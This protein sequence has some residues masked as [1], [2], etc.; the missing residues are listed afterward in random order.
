MDTVV[1]GGMCTSSTHLLKISKNILTWSLE[2]L[3]HMQ[4]G[5][6][7]IKHRTWRDLS[8]RSLFT[9]LFSEV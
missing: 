1:A 9:Y 8:F 2:K 5:S 6:P 4:L 3:T 7:R